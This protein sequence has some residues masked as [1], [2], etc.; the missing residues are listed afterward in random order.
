[1]NL[2]S[3]GWLTRDGKLV[4]AARVVKTFAYG[5]LSKVLAIY[6]KLIGFDD[7]LIGLVLA[8]TLANSVILTA[9][10]SFYADRV[11]RRK[12]LVI[13]TILMA[14][15]GATFLATGNP[16]ALIVAALAGTINVTGSE[17]GAFLSV[18]QALLP[19]TVTDPKRRNTV[20]ALY[21]MA[22]TFAMSAGVLLSGLPA[23]LQQYYGLNQIESIRPLFLLYSM[24]G[25]AVAA[26]YL[27]LST[28]IELPEKGS[29]RPLT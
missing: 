12:I 18:E 20:F 11:G 24:L 27:A 13:Y 29:A 6:L 4:L 21:N 23:L 14:A 15:A 9:M 26:I 25:V 5:F 7:V 16:V 17:T 1:M 22:G 2:L 19:Q 28:K 3:V 10:A 8:A